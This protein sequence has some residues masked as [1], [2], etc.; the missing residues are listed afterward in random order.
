MA[1]AET[2]AQGR[3]D[4]VDGFDGMYERDVATRHLGIEIFDVRPGAAK[5]RMTVAPYMVQGHG[6]AHGGY[7]FTFADSVFAFACNSHG[8]RTVARSAEIVFVRPAYAGDE[9]LAEATERVLQGRSGIYDVTV[10]RASDAAVV[11]E[12]RGQ[13]ARVGTGAAPNQATGE[14]QA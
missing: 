7:L 3:A 11:A 5:G 6:T 10:R 1:D 9:L 13:S 2:V 12:F 8:P 14:S 4:G